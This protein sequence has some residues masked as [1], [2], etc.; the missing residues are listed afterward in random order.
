[1]TIGVFVMGSTINPLMVISICIGLGPR[2]LHGSLEPFGC[3]A[4]LS[5]H[6]VRARTLDANV[7]CA[8]DPTAV[9]GQVDDGV[10]RGS[11]GEFGLAPATGSVDQDF[12]RGA[13]HR[14]VDVCL[15]GAL[16]RLE[17]DNP[18]G[19]VVLR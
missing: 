19:L 8:A 15:D 11:P 2:A 12:N 16:H 14:F 9:A 10:L 4:H 13:D 3:Q 1:M 17:F 5:P 18:P 7:Y 6:A